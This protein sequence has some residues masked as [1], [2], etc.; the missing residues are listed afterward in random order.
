MNT[1]SVRDI[2]L[3]FNGESLIP[4]LLAAAI[5]YFAYVS[6]K[7]TRRYMLIVTAGFVLLVYNS[8]FLRFV[9]L[10]GLGESY[11]RF[12]WMIPVVPLVSAAL[13]HAVKRIPNK[14]GKAALLIVTAVILCVPGV[15]YL[16]KSNLKLPGNIY[17][18]PQETIEVC[19]M[20]REDSDRE[21]LNVAVGMGL[22]MTMRQYDANFEFA[23]TRAAY[24]KRE[25]QG[26]VGK[27]KKKERFL[28]SVVDHGK[29][30][31][32][33]KFKRRIQKRQI[34]YLVIR[35]EYEMDDYM[36]DVGCSVV[37]R[38]GTYTVYRNDALTNS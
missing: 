5:L 34:E 11:Y 37:D 31:G 38:S 14:V 13:V 29:K 27:G 35:T 8:L 18:L 16:K 3:L 26:Y 20:I 24:L 23:F 15:T 28:I 33:R 30:R 36:K 12:F 4:V 17:N 25:E 6:G 19:E 2:F 1:N 22:Q 21:H 7:K 10:F 9:K 32:K